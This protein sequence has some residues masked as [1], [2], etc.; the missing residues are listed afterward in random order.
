MRKGDSHVLTD[1]L[2]LTHTGVRAADTVTSETVVI[3]LVRR[4]AVARS[5]S[6]SFCDNA[7]SG[8]TLTNVTLKGLAWPRR[9]PVSEH[10]DMQ[11]KSAYCSKAYS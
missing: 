10:T 1:C 4:N 8:G 9:E 6:E 11:F 5:G 7:L 2:T 3:S